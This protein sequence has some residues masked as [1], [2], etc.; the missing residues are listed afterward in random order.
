[1][2]GNPRSFLG[3]AHILAAKF[4]TDKGMDCVDVF[5]G[6]GAK[7]DVVQAGTVLI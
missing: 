1:M 2:A 5:V 4:V 3:R 7:T 6:A